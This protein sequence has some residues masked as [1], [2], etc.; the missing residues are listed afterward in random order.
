MSTG[1]FGCWIEIVPFHHYQMQ[2]LFG[3]HIK[4]G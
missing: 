2:G 4:C 3:I 1:C